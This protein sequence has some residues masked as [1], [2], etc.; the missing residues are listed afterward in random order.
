MVI[1]GGKP[2]NTGKKLTPE[3]RAKIGKSGKGRVMAIESREKLSKSITGHPV[4]LETRAGWDVDTGHIEDLS[5]HGEDLI[6]LEQQLAR[7]ENELRY[8]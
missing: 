3:H 8:G 7:F 6:V 2:W 4:S 5:I 1:K